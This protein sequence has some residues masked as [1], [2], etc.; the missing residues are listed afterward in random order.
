[1]NEGTGR[2]G[3]LDTSIPGDAQVEI[4]NEAA[5]MGLWLQNFPPSRRPASSSTH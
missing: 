4:Q 5:T 1:M 3:H 2:V